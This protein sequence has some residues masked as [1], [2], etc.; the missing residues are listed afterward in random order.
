[1][2]P[3]TNGGVFL[4][5]LV[6]RRP[7]Y[8]QSA[9]TANFHY[10]IALPD[11]TTRAADIE[12]RIPAEDRIPFEGAYDDA[13]K[14]ALQ[15]QAFNGPLHDWLHPQ[16]PM[17]Q[18]IGIEQDR[19]GNLFMGRLSGDH[20]CHLGPLFVDG[21]FFDAN[22]REVSITARTD[23]ADGMRLIGIVGKDRVLDM[24]STTSAKV[25]NPLKPNPTPPANP[26]IDPT[27]CPTAP[28]P[29]APSHHD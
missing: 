25:V 17:W 12:A 2:I 11:G 7:G 24:R 3:P 27:P 14:A 20:R 8:E 15:Q 26:P 23:A 29:N 5:P 22:A 16:M 13:V 10:H 18:A 9:T 28:D 4:P 19:A 1:V 21:P 6:A